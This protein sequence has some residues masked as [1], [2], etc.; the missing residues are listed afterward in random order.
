[1]RSEREQIHAMF[2][3]L[4]NSSPKTFPLLG[5]RLDAPKKRG[6]Y[7]IYAQD[8]DV[9]HVGSTPWANNGI[10]QRLRDH[11]FGRSSFTIKNFDSDGSRLRGSHQY[12]YLVVDDG[13]TRALLEALAI[14]LL[15]PYHIGHGHTAEISN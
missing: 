4:V 6:V 1:M 10:A 11:M 7:I 13:R 9:L 5:G 14:G 15:C 3:E 8:G 12:R 2:L